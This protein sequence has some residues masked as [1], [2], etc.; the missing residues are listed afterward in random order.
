MNA[1]LVPPTGLPEVRLEPLTLDRLDQLLAVEAQAYEFPWSRGNFTDSLTSG[2]AVQLLCAGEHLL[3]YYVAMRGVEETHLLNLTVAP[4]F[5]RQGWARV[6]LDALA[7]W[8]RSQGAHWLWLEVRAS[9]APAR[10]LYKSHGFHHV[11]HRPRYYPAAGGT[12]EDAVVM[13]LEL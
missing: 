4:T 12:R 1:V 13:S 9:N 10:A 7:L 6:L 5:R 8:S 2:Y 3:G 11:G